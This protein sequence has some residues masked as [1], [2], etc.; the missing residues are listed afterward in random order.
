MEVLMIRDF[1]VS[2]SQTLFSWLEARADR[3]WAR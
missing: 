2:L 1:M 3:Y